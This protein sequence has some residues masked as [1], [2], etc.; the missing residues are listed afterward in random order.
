MTVATK[1]NDLEALLGADAKSLLEHKCVGIPKETHP[2]PRARTRSTASSRSSDRPI[3]VLRSL[4]AASQPRPPRPA[5]ATSRSCPSTRA[6]S[7]RPARPS[8]RTRSTSTRRTSSSSPS[9]AAATRVAS[10]LGVLGS[11]AR[12]YA[13]KIPF[14]VKFNHNELLSYPNKFDQTL[15]GSVEQA[16]DMGASAVGAT[17]LLRLGRSRAARS[18]R[19]AEAFARAHEL[20]MATI[21]WCYMRNNAFKTA[22][23]GLPRRPPTS[24]ARPTTSA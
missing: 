17:D 18:G 22:G 16:C 9:R 24:P 5:P 8:P 10:T 14:I 15:F 21:L 3:P 4:A 13:H 7:T 6:S 2:R 20:G 11:V 12:K 1:T 23:E 19:S